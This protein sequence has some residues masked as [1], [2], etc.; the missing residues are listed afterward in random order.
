MSTCQVRRD[1]RDGLRA[2]AL[3]AELAD[4]PALLVASSR[5]WTI[6]RWP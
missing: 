1:P 2:V 6:S 4:A 3:S 5:R